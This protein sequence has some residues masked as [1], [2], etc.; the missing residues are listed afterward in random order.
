LHLGEQLGRV[1]S[2]VDHRAVRKPAQEFRRPLAREFALRRGF[3]R[4]MGPIRADALIPA[5]LN[6]EPRT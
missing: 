4:D 5:S 6:L 3:E 2:L 1:V